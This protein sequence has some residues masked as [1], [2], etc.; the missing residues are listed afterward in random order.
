VAHKVVNES[1]EK[2][3]EDDYQDPHDLLVAGIS[4]PGGAVYQHPYPE[5]DPECRAKEDKTK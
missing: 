2:L 1:P 3:N 5:C 4:F